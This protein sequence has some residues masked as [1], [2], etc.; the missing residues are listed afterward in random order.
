MAGPFQV[1]TSAV[2]TEISEYLL[3]DDGAEEN[4]E[5][6]QV[7]FYG[8]D[9]QGCSIQEVVLTVGTVVTRYVIVLPHS[10]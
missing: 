6:G 8:T 1:T 10:Q 5:D 3:S 9:L 2:L 7:L 4:P